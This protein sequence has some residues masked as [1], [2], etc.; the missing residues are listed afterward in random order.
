MINENGILAHPH[1]AFSF[2]GGMATKPDCS[3]MTATP[4]TRSGQPVV[5]DIR[6][7]GRSKLGEWCYFKL[8]HFAIAQFRIAFDTFQAPL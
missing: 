3:K 5:T 1:P 4:V 8:L 6:K 2:L 7:C